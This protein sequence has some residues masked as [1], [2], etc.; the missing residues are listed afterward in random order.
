M[1][2]INIDKHPVSA[3]ILLFFLAMIWGSSFILMKKGLKAF[4]PAEI[5]GIR[6]LSASFFLF[7]IAL[8]QISKIRHR[9]WNYLFLSGFFGSLLPAFLFPLAQTRIDSSIT[10]VLNSLTP[11]FTIL[12][13]A[14]LFKAR[15]NIRV[16]TGI[17]L[18]L[19]GTTILVTSNGTGSA[20][21]IN[22]Y[23]LFIILATT[24]YGLNVNLLKYNLGDLHPL[25]ITSISMMMISPFAL[26]YLL[27][28]SDIITTLTNDAES[29]IPLIYVLILGVIGT[30]FALVLFNVLIKMTNTVFSSSVTY[31]IPLIAVMW[32]L[33]DGESLIWSHYLGM[34]GIIMG[35]IIAN[36]HKNY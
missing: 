9:H 29:F 25:H 24:F 23:V 10:G 26:G 22:V 16:I 32:G 21:E 27:T 13:G 18:G 28:S 34:T 4:D 17:V 19:A 6:I 30:A 31:L 5:A 8:R 33:M 1:S 2:K 3:W 15:F 35:V 11:L 7:P 36:Y 14:T 20:F 12:L